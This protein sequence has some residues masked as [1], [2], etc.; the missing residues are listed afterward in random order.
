MDHP[1]SLPAAFFRPPRLT[2][3]AGGRSSIPATL[4]RSAVFTSMGRPC[5][6]IVSKLLDGL[7]SILG[8]QVE[9]VPS[10]IVELNALA[11]HCDLRGDML[12]VPSRQRESVIGGMVTPRSDGYV[13]PCIPTRAYKVP[14]GPG[15]VHEI[16]HD[17]YRL[18]V[19]RNCCLGPR[20]AGMT[21]ACPYSGS[22]RPILRCRRSPQC[23][24][25]AASPDAVNGCENNVANNAPRKSARSC[26]RSV[27]FQ[28][29]PSHDGVFGVLIDTAEMRILLVA[30]RR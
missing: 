7:H 23:P 5:F 4:W 6:C 13:Q 1:L 14:A 19:R 30:D 25:G 29:S 26:R 15:L 20:L 8:K 24:A 11:G 21:R 18:Q 22:P 12:A 28:A 27:R 3:A 9:G 16:K 10:L 2:D 17:G